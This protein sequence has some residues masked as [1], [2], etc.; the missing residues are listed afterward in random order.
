MIDENINQ[1]LFFYSNIL[2]IIVF[3]FLPL[4]LVSNPPESL[5]CI[6]IDLNTITTYDDECFGL[7]ICFS[8]WFEN[9]EVILL[10]TE[11]YY[12]YVQQFFF[13][14]IFELIDLT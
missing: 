3:L 8:I 12:L 1:C 5:Y 4:V 6:H 10:L 14:D 7:E 9:D 2:P 11:E 13:L